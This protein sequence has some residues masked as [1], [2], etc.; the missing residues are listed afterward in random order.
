MEVF[1][2]A[3]ALGS[4]LGHLPWRPVPGAELLDSLPPGT[5]LVLDEGRPHATRFH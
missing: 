3:L 2:S 5:E 4:R 1:T